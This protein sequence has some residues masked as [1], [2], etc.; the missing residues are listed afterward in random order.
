MKALTSHY[1][2]AHKFEEE[3]AETKCK[4]AQAKALRE[5]FIG[6][7]GLDGEIRV[8]L[9]DLETTGLINKHVNM[10]LPK[11]IEIG[12]KEMGTG[13]AFET[14]VNPGMDIPE[15][16]TKINNITDE[17][18][19]PFPM[20]E[21]VGQ[22]LKEWIASIT[23]ERDV[24]LLIAHNMIKF[25]QRILQGEMEEANLNLPV[26]WR[27]ADSISLFKRH[28]AIPKKKGTKPYSLDSLYHHLFNED[29][30]IAHRAMGDVVA[31][32]RCLCEVFKGKGG[33]DELAADDVRNN[34]VNALFVIDDHNK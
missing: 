7:E 14:L 20:F 10:H 28:V 16:A 18:V 1:M 25:D 33:E 3:S 5:N 27:Y 30:P 24:V 8:F 23:S 19:A 6:V 9:L 15:A 4:E 11:I 22:M 2:T 34:I 17:M 26:N 13:Q 29:M 12:V 21:R 32:E 31:L